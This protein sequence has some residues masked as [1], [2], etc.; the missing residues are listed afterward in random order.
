MKYVLGRAF[1]SITKKV[2]SIKCYCHISHSYHI[3]LDVDQGF[4]Y[5]FY[6]LENLT[7][8]VLSFSYTLFLPFF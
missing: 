6:I 4:M 2:S 7:M 1:I 8:R 5:M 3:T